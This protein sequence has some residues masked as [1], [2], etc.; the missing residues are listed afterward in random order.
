MPRKASNLT[1]RVAQVLR[2]V[3]KLKRKGINKAD[4]YDFTRATDVFAAVRDKL[5]AA[6]ILLLPNEGQP[7]YVDRTTNGGELLQE[8]RLPVIYTLTDGIDKLP[9]LTCHG[10][11]RDLSDKALYKAQTGA[12]KAFLKRIGLMAEEVDDPEYDGKAA[13][14]TLDDVAPRRTPRKEK[15]LAAYQI[16][17]VQAAM[18]ATGKTEE[19]LVAMVAKFGAAGLADVKQRHFK[20]LLMW[21]SDGRG[22]IAAPAAPKLTAVPDQAQAT[23]PL[24]AAPQPVELKIGS[25]KIEFEPRQSAYSV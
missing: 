14:E 11:A 4:G 24:R 9:P 16:E 19:Q 10:I 21:A 6:G 8:C 18:Q 20:E 22:T 23:L 5:F 12:E 17:N 25:Q 1:T 15:P 13:S 7:E 3:E 2:Q